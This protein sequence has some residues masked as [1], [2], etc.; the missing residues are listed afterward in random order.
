MKRLLVSLFVVV[1]TSQY[2]FAEAP[3]AVGSK[4]V[5]V[6]DE[7]RPYDQ[8]AGVDVGVRSLI[9]EIWYPI[10]KDNTS[11]LARAT[12]GDY[13]FGDKDVHRLMLTNTTFFHLTPE[14]VVEG[15]TQAQI[16]AA[17]EEL[18]NRP[19]SSYKDAPA[20]ENNDGWPVVVMTHGDAGSRYNM[21]TACET[22]A[23]HGYV[24]IAP[25][26]TGNTPFAFT[27]KDPEIDGKLA[28]IKPL[29]NEDGT[30]GPMKDYGQTY[31][32][33]VSDRDNPKALVKLDDAL[34]ERVNDLRA[35]LNE[36]DQMNKSGEFA[37]SLDLSKVGLM[38]RSFGGTTTL[39]ALALEPRFT[40]GVSVVPLVMPDPRPGLPEELL[41]AEG[42]ESIIL[43][44]SGPAVL[45]SL[46]KP[47]MLLSGAED[48][49]IIGVGAHMAKASGGELATPENPLPALRAS[50]DE[51]DQ[52]VIWGL[53]QDSN[54]SSFGVSG[55][56]WWPELK[57]KTQQRF[58]EPDVT[59]DLIEAKL[60]HQIQQEKTLQFFNYFIRDK[61]D[62]KKALLKNEFEQQ[63]LIYE[64]RNF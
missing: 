49:L 6:H 64:S 56:Y 12:Y 31:T 45:N 25:E 7:S 42:E 24:V 11:K 3:Y 35:V 16:D 62:A 34:L 4:T 36:L 26:H 19:R 61:A 1:M 8:V 20:L 55:G 27:A 30:Y 32:P 5:F 14:S 47:T 51:S 33:L 57:A 58:F 43:A 63:G 2:A 39:A 28:A 41:K 21:E 60:A 46:T 54:H 22:L 38:G 13:S 53:L 44:A 18:Y 29:L 37:G 9:T 48:A 52:P 23:A 40:A 10:E 17:I 59:F 50:Y 15:V